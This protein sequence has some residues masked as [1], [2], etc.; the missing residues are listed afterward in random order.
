MKRKLVF[1]T[2]AAAIAV[3]GAAAPATG[4]FAAISQQCVNNGGNLAPGQQTSCS[5]QGQTQ[6]A[7]NPAGHLPPGQQP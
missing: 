6:Q 4:A 1:A 7:V 2:C 3:A 5:G